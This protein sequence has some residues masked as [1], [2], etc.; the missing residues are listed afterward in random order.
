MFFLFFYQ[1]LSKFVGFHEVNINT[2]LFHGNFPVKVK[3]MITNR[4][5]IRFNN[6]KPALKFQLCLICRISICLHCL[7][8]SQSCFEIA[9]RYSVPHNRSD[10]SNPKQTARKGSLKSGRTDQN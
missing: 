6:M 5:I 4:D 7:P 1:N 3:P 8:R 2:K 10:S 9:V